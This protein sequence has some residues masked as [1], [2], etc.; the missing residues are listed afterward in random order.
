EIEATKELISAH[1]EAGYTS[2]AI[3][4][5][6]LY[7]FEGK[8]IKEELEDN[9]KATTTIAKFIEERMG[10]KEF[11]L[12][13]E[14]GEIGKEDAQGRVLTTPEEAVT[15]I[16]ALNENGVYPQVLAIANGSAHGNIYDENG[17]AIEQISIDIPQTKAVVA[18]L[19]KANLAVNVA[20][21]GITGTPR[22]LIQSQFPKGDIIKGNVA[23]FWMNLVWDVLKVFEPELYAKIYGWTLDYFRPK[24]PDMKDHQIFGTYGKFAMAQFFDEISAVDKSTVRAIEAYAYAESLMFFKAFNSEG[25]GSIVRAALKG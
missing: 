23:T 13:V 22:D 5:S 20:Q 19:K 4:A 16:Q 24:F 15:Y 10:G 3:D 21:H 11:G 1:I 25:T 7:N 2:F 9:I 6:H 8:N 18:A 17:N 14:V 12:E